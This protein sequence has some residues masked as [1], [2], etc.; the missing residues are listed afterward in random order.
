M[1]SSNKILQP[2]GKEIKNILSVCIVKKCH[3]IV[4]M[5]N[6]ISRHH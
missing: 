5:S 6:I 4:V 1:Q 2:V 3:S